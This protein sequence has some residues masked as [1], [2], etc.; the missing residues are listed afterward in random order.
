SIFNL[1]PVLSSA[2]TS[3]V[4]SLSLRYS[5]KLNVFRKVSLT[6]FSAPSRAS[7]ALSSAINNLWVHSQNIEL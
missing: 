7:I 1:L 3:R 2:L 6:I 5:C 4:E